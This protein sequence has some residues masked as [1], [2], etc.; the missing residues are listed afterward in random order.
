MRL[1]ER[2]RQELV[3]AKMMKSQNSISVIHSF[4]ELLSEMTCK[5]FKPSIRTWY[6]HGRDQGEIQFGKVTFSLR[7]TTWQVTIAT[8]KDNF[9]IRS[10]VLLDLPRFLRSTDPLKVIFQMLERT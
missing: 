10:Q 4:C 2:V 6:A 3:S 7:N 5:L 9:K 1:R 8:K